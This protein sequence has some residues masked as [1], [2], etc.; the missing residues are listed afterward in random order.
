MCS[1]NLYVMSVEQCVMSLFN[2]DNSIL[3]SFSVNSI[4]FGRVSIRTNICKKNIAIETLELC[5]PPTIVLYNKLF[6]NVNAKSMFLTILCIE[7]PFLCGSPKCSFSTQKRVMRILNAIIRQYMQKWNTM[8]VAQNTYIIRRQSDCAS[9]S[10]LPPT[11]TYLLHIVLCCTCDA[12]VFRIYMFALWK[13][14]GGLNHMCVLRCYYARQRLR[15]GP[16]IRGF[17]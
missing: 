2:S 7:M 1:F 4:F 17:Y 10:I 13:Q 15:F 3:M 8:H 5:S 16:S 11:I 6:E 12:Q 9:S 14:T